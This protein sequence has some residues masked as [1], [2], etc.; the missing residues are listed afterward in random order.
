MVGRL[1]SG[2][3]VAAKA[4]ASNSPNGSARIYLQSLQ[5]FFLHFTKFLQS[6][7]SFTICTKFLGNLQS[8]QSLQSFHNVHKVFQNV[9]NALTKF[10]KFKNVLQSSQSVT[11]SITGLFLNIEFTKAYNI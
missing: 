11:K 8:V 6:L 9:Y 7:Y 2:L 1:Y 4:A 3:R 5:N 10:T